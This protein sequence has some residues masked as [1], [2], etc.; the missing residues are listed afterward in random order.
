M[1]ALK[2]EGYLNE[3]VGAGYLERNWPTAL[4][5]SGVWSLAGLRKS[6]L[7]GSLT[8]LPDPE[9]ALKAAIPRLVERGEF[10]LASDPKPDSS[11]GRVWFRELVPSEEVTFDSETFL[12]VEDE[13]GGSISGASIH[14][15]PPRDPSSGSRTRLASSRC[16]IRRR[17]VRSDSSRTPGVSLR[18]R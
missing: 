15:P 8:R 5:A 7:D 13:S 16:R 17:T 14:H 4:R 3:S 1:A 9:E 11:Y 18:S 2:S 12:I 6:F 10:G